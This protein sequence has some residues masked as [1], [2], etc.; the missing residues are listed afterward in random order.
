MPGDGAGWLSTRDRPARRTP[1]G[2]GAGR[3]DAV[4]IYPAGRWRRSQAGDGARRWATAGRP[5]PG[6]AGTAVVTR[7]SARAETAVL[8][9]ADSAELTDAE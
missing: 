6:A 7:L 5:L 2:L 3:L 1:Y 8:T 9:G 4:F